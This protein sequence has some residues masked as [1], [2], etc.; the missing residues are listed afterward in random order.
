MEEFVRVRLK[1]VV[2][3]SVMCECRKIG[4]WEKITSAQG[5]V[6]EIKSNREI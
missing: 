3:C 6:A 5:F 4:F 2:A 1:G